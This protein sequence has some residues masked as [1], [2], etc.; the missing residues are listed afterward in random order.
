MGRIANWWSSRWTRVGVVLVA[1]G[2]LPLLGYCLWDTLFGDPDNPGN[3]VGLGL[4]SAF[5]GWPGIICIVYGSARGNDRARERA[6][7]GE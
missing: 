5:L 6:G 2:F 7:R 3:P 4:L 1:I